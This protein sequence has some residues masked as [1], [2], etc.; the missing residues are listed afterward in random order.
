L[1]VPGDISNKVINWESF[2]QFRRLGYLAA[3]AGIALFFLF[4]S[5]MARRTF[6]FYTFDRGKSVVEARMLPKTA[7]PELDITRYTEEALLGPVSIEFAPLVVRGTKLRSLIF[8]EGTVWADL[9]GEA[10]LPVPETKT[11]V[12]EGILALNRGIRRN[13]PAVRDVKIFIGGN[14][15]YNRE[16]AEIFAK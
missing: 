11:G 2:K 4:S 14:E 3:L 13:F 15:V 5:G 16:F 6:E 12:Y 9:S 7:S 1:K 8:R 10:A